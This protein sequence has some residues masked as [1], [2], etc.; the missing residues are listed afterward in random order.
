M[1]LQSRAARKLQSEAKKKK[2]IEKEAGIKR[3]GK[4]LQS[5]A[6]ITKLQSRS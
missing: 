5:E 2:K 1:Y 4:K 3:R 6:G